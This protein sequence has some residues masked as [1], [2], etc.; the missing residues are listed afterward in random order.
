[1]TVRTDPYMSFLKINKKSCG[2]FGPL[3]SVASQR[4]QGFN[5]R[6]TAISTTKLAS[7]NNLSVIFD[8]SNIPLPSQRI[9]T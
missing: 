4:H 5:F 3:F 2:G 7:S 6:V 8:P 9:R 1:M